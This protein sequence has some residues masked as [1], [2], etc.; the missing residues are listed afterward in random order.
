MQTKETHLIDKTE[1]LVFFV[2]TSFSDP[3]I[4]FYAHPAVFGYPS[5]NSAPLSTLFHRTLAT[6]EP[7]CPPPVGPDAIA[8]P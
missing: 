1:Q 6:T 3:K 8:N 2:H 4:Q 5:R 7:L